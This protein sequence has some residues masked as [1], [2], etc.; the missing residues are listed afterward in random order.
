MGAGLPNITGSFC[1]LPQN[2]NNRQVE[3]CFYM[4][5]VPTYK[6]STWGSNGVN[7]NTQAGFDASLNGNIIYGNSSTVTPKS[8]ATVFLVKY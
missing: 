5:T 7:A 4:K 1:I 6:R 8:R 2:R 3:G